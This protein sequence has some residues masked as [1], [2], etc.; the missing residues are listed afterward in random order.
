[1]KLVKEI[2]IKKGAVARITVERKEIEVKNFVMDELEARIEKKIWEETLIEVIMNG[3]VATDATHVMFVMAEHS[4]VAS[5]L[6]KG[7]GDYVAKIG[8]AVIS[9]DKK[10]KE[11]DNAMKEMLEEV[12][13]ATADLGKT[14]DEKTAEKQEAKK[15]E[16]EEKIVENAEKQIEKNG[17]LK[18]AEEVKELIDQYTDAQNEG[19]ADEFNPYRY[20]IS[21]E[22]YEQAKAFLGGLK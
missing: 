14:D 22:R 5:K 4:A 18:S 13:Q 21:K 2:E 7:K 10:A 1:M 3:K 20:M 8:D 16:H 12:R 17:G 9:N 11:I 15:V 6:G 19:N